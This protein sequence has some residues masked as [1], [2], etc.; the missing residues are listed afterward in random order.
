MEI[1]WVSA[2]VSAIVFVL[3][4][5]L[6][7]HWH[8][9]M[10][11]QSWTIRN[12]AERVKDLEDVGDPEFRRRLGDSSP[13]PLEQVFHFSF[14]LSD[15]FWRDQLGI[16]SEDRDLI[17]ASGSFVASVKLEYWRSHTVATVT[18]ILSEKA[19]RGGKR[20]HSIFI[21]MPSGIPRNFPCGSF[22]FHRQRKLRVQLLWN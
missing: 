18:E 3:F 19:R 20:G 7:Q 14:R 8:A 22:G 1:L 13:M 16:K 10:R 6:A 21:R 5:T 17:R 12:L 2:G 9:I 11:Q 4:F 15:C